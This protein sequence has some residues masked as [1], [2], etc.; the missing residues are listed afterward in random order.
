MGLLTIFSG[1]EFDEI[2]KLIS[3]YGTVRDLHMRTMFGGSKYLKGQ[4][5]EKFLM[6]EYLP[7]E[8]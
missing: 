2:T 3:F 5:D 6:D 7:Q 8:L 4:S 1:Y